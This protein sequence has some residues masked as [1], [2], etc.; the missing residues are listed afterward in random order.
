M[1]TR[2][3][4]RHPFLPPDDERHAAILHVVKGRVDKL[5]LAQH[6]ATF[7]RIAARVRVTYTPNA[8]TNHQSTDW[9]NLSTCQAATQ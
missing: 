8:A 1:K 9:V 5:V 7:R 6:V 3:R 4:P 2:T